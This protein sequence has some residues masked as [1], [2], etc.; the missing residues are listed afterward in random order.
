[1][2]NKPDL[3][4]IIVNWNVR[5]LLRDCLQS[6]LV[7]IDQNRLSAAVWVVD[8]ASEDDSV[9]MIQAEFPRV[10]LIA[11]RSNLGF[12]GSNN[13]ALHALG[14]PGHQPEQPDL[15]LLLNPDT[16]VKPG[17]LKAMV[18]F[19]GSHPEAGMAGANLSFGDG[20]FQHGAYAFPG[21]WQLAIELLPLPGRLVESRLNG[22]YPPALYAGQVPFPV[23]HPLG[24]AMMV[25]AAAIH[26]AGVLDDG[27]EMY[28][29]EVDWAWRIKQQGWAAYCVPQAAI[30]HFGGQ[31]TG[32]IRARSFLQLWRSRY[33]FY[34]KR[35]G[36]LRL[37]LARQ[38]VVR[39]MQRLMVQHPEQ[40][41][42]FRRVQLIWQGKAL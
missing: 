34:R 24:A 33:R 10:H 27:Y 37:T 9:A 5:D 14:F 30:V 11:S 18:D 42:L 23:D 41:E 3:A 17:A 12:A 1:M 25:R 29:E 22:R 36:W 15:V 8:S 31:S 39:G 20:S 16:L 19:M 26:T 40:Q 6:V 38:V 13:L 2:S 7:E 35:Y 32:Q 4:I 21:L 28:V